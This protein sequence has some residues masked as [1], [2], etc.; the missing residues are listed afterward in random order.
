MAIPSLM[1]G[2]VPLSLATSRLAASI[3]QGQFEIQRLQDQLSSGR[4]F[5]LPSEDPTA[6]T[7]TLALQKLDERRNSYQNSISVVQ[8]SLGAT[9]QA[10][11]SLGETL[12]TARGLV[13]AGIGSQTS[14]AERSGLAQEAASL[15]QSAL[16]AMNTSYN[17]RYIFAGTQTE[18][19]PFTVQGDGSIRYQGD[20][21]AI[22]TFADFGFQI[23]GSVD[24]GRDL[25][26]LSQS[27]TVD[28]NPALT[29]STR[30]DQLQGGTGVAPQIIRVTLDNSPTDTVQKTVDLTGAQTIQDVKS[31][32]EAAFA[33]ETITLTVDI[34][35]TSKNGLRL[36]PSVG[37]V[38]VDDLDHGRTASALGIRSAPVAVLQGTDLNPAINL[39]TAVSDLNGGTGIGATAGTG[40]RIEHAGKV[41]IVD[42]DGAATVQDVLNRI[43]AADPDVYAEIAADGSGVRVASRLSGATFS[44]GENGG[45]NAAGLGLRTFTGASALVELNLGAGVP[46]LSSNPLQITRRDGSTVEVSLAGA[47][48]IQDVLDKLNAVDPGHLVAGLNPTGNG[49]SLTDDSGTDPLTVVENA[50]STALGLNGTNNAGTAGVL[51]GKD[52][53]P[54]QPTGTLTL[55]VTLQRA[56]ENNDQATLNRLA[57]QLEGET[58]RV[59]VVRADVG[60][61]QMLMTDVN[62]H[63]EDARI[64]LK[65]TISELFETDFATTVTQFLQHQQALQGAMQ[66]SSEALKLSVLQYL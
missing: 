32:L 64:N 39:Y 45:T 14:S 61:R 48:T 17:G 35:P 47:N 25:L 16:L 62:N 3:T 41:R 52:V 18:Q 22:N 44:I 40:L 57:G 31:R 58:K 51:A 43:R 42:L 10:L 9:D 63:L 6:A 54:Q 55:L 53:N 33:T 49:I 37:T 13:Q 60:T 38:A 23:S 34:D 46:D 65:Q 56:L 15:I 20:E 36:T 30:L 5:I 27:P 26:A 28:L 4:R 7:Q 66:V 11:A 19:L 21:G 8:G 59:S 2:R 50:M 24:G 12:N 1:P 29:L